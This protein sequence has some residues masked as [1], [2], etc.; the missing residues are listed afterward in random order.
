MVI[1]MKNTIL[2]FLGRDSGFGE[3]NTSAYFISDNE[4]NIIDCG[5]D[6]FQKVKNKFNLN[7]FSKINIII[8]HLHNDHAGSLSQ[9]IL[10]LWFVYNKKA[11]I[12]CACKYIKTYLEITGVPVEAYRIQKDISD[13]K[14]I[15]TNH[16]EFIEAYGFKMNIDNKTIVYTGDTNVIEP[17]LP[18][19]DNAD[20]LYIDV[21]KC[22]G[23]HL[24]IDDILE[25]LLKIK[26]NGTNIILMHM[27][28]RDYIEK[29]AQ[30]LI[31]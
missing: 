24:K 21:S 31:N 13:I 3:N 1:E 8:T 2:T 20:E 30:K 26:L 5:C 9:L 25:E 28:D 10:Y 15:K 18:Y 11:N 16:S 17:F 27:D 23:A 12:I 22:G 19:L 7:D 6:V 4:L 29:I 14:F